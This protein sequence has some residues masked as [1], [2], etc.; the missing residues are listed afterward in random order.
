MKNTKIAKVKRRIEIEFV[1][2][3]RTPAPFGVGVP[4]VV[5]RRPTFPQ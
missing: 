1:K 3:R 4:V 2:N 5:G